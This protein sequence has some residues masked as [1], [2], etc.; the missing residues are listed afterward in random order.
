[1]AG[2][3]LWNFEPNYKQKLKQV[4]TKIKKFC[5]HDQTEVVIYLFFYRTRIGYIL[6]LWCNS[7]SVSLPAKAF[8]EMLDYVE[9]LD[10]VCP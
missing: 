10:Y 5:R 9:A 7:P 1:L 3:V 4:E 2:K 6:Q 8:A